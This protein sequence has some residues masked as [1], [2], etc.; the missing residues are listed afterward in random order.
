MNVE[1]WFYCPPAVL[2]M[3]VDGKYVTC[4]RGLLEVRGKDC[5]K[6]ARGCVFEAGSQRKSEKPWQ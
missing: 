6:G 4:F 3:L 5:G 1:V 2:L